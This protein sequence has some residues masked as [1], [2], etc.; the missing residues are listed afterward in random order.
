[1]D[2]EIET[3]PDVKIRQFNRKKDWE[4]IIEQACTWEGHYDNGDD[5]YL[6]VKE[7]MPFVDRVAEAERRSRVTDKAVS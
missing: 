3:T 2:I 1:M 4:W 5:A 6:L 7:H